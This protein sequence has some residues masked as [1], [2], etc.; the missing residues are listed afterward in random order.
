LTR[1]P[2]PQRIFGTVKAFAERGR[3]LSRSELESLGDSRDIAELVT[4]LKN[5]S[6]GDVLQ[7]LQGPYTATTLENTLKENLFRFHISMSK[8]VSSKDLIDAYYTRYIIWNLKTILK[9]KILG[10]TYD[11]IAPNVNLYAEELIGRRDVVVK[12]LVAKDLEEAVSSLQSSEF[13]PDAQNASNIYKEKGDF[14]I[15]DLVLDRTYFNL[16]TS[17][18]SKMGKP[19]D[20]QPLVAL[21]VDSYNVTSTLRGKFWG[22]NVD[23]I[24][25]LR[26][27]PTFRIEEETL[28]KMISAET[29]KDAVTELSNTS[30]RN[31]VPDR[32]LNDI[33]TISKIEDSFDKQSYRRSMLSYPKM[34]SYATMIAAIKLKQFE[35]RNLATVCFGVEQHLGSKNIMPHLMV[36][37]NL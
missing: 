21:D 31:L 33:E 5:T 14:Q 27:T 19:M 24:K 28:D 30:Y 2:K 6:Y 36:P 10:R 23:Q 12:A 18:F 9:G 22:L 37:E 25:N 17:A 29:I 7:Q 11:E 34:F 15:F 35:A 4:K 32:E 1:I 13:G 8:I 20:V 26:V 3:L 16:L